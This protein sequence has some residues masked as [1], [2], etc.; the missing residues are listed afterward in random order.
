MSQNNTVSKSRA[1][2]MEY[3]TFLGIAWSIVF[4]LYATSITKNNIL[5][6]LLSSGLL[7]LL[8]ILAFYL[9]WRYSAKSLTQSISWIQSWSFVFMMFVYASLLTGAVEFI[10]F[11]YLDNG[12]LFQS[13][14]DMAYDEVLFD[15]Y[16]NAGM[17]NYVLTLRESI[18]TILQISTIDLTL[19][20]FNQNIFTGMLLSI[21][22]MII[23]KKMNQ[24]SINKP[25]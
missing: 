4:I 13:I 6:M 9:S 10:Y 7:I 17:E 12:A 8:P 24:K 14:K 2:A 25:S 15:T 21:P 22:C 16:K 5:L 1:Y 23:V 20:L 3:G 11:K 19:S 18:D